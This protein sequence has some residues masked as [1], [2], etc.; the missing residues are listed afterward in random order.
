[1]SAGPVR[2]WVVAAPAVLP[3]TSVATALR[4]MQEAGLPALPVACEGRFV[5]LVH[6][7]DLLRLAPFEA[8]TLDR[9]ELHDVL[10]RLK[11]AR[12]VQPSAAVSP[13]CPLEEAA[14]RMAEQRALVLPVVSEGLPVGLLLWTSVL[15][16]L[17]SREV[18]RAG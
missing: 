11:V 15:Q 17:V 10:G 14:R 5:G 2:A 4:L 9:Y 1:V 16:A 12:V 13:D 6:E 18:R 7:R 8:T 3:T